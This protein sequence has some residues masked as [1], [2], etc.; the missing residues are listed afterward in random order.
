[1]KLVA[2]ARSL[3]RRIH[4]L[5]IYYSTIDWFTCHT[6]VNNLEQNIHLQIFLIPGLDAQP[7]TIQTLN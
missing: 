5:R 2:S 1:M 6:V 3:W 4:P 7:F